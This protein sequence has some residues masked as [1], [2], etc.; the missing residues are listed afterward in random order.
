LYD[1][2]GYCWAG[3]A[4]G[5]VVVVRCGVVLLLVGWFARIYVNAGRLWWLYVCMG[6]ISI[7]AGEVVVVRCVGVLLPVGFRA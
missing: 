3:T 2:T 1:T 5:E 6:E 7:T 4:A